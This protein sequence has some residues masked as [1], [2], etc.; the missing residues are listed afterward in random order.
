L[1][2]YSIRTES[3]LH[4]YLKLKHSIQKK[5]PLLELTR[6]GTFYLIMF[7]VLISSE[8]SCP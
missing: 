1:N 2:Y 8:V 4:S 6:S 5:I 7:L 3:I